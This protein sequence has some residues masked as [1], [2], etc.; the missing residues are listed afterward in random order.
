MNLTWVYYDEADEIDFNVVS[1]L[2]EISIHNFLNKLNEQ[3]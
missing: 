2:F 3:K 1:T